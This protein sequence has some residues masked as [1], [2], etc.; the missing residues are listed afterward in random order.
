MA[1][2]TVKLPLPPRIDV[3]KS[4][5]AQLQPTLVPIPPPKSPIVTREQDLA[6]WFNL[7][8]AQE[9][10][11]SPDV[12]G[13]DGGRQVNRQDFEGA[14]SISSGDQDLAISFNLSIAQ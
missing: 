6:I 1:N 4:S 9:Q 14:V 7:S 10:L 3:P 5:P 13:E 12:K 2:S 11:V 8:I